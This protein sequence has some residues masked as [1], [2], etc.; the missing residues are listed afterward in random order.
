MLVL[1]VQYVEKDWG[2]NVLCWDLLGNYEYLSYWRS[3]LPLMEPRCL[4]SLRGSE[5]HSL[6]SAGSHVNTFCT[7]TSY[8]L[9]IY[10]S[11]IIWHMWKSSKWSFPFLP[12]F[13][14]HILF[15]SLSLSLIWLSNQYFWGLQ[16][17]KIFTTHV[18]PSS[19]YFLS[20][21]YVYFP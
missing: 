21:R 6:V 13:Y 18:S 3:F 4:Y 10:F 20:L 15:L 17:M 5:E 8:L 11:G 19:C 14:M 9:S 16:I 7:L 12:T 2:K 1:T